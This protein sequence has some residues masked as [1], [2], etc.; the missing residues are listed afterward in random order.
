MVGQ[1]LEKKLKE[2]QGCYF[3]DKYNTLQKCTNILKQPFVKRS[4]LTLKKMVKMMTETD[5]CN[6]PA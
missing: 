4:M 1:L 6:V 2:Q 3:S 5:F